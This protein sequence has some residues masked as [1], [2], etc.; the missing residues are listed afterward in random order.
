MTNYKTTNQMI[1]IAQETISISNEKAYLDLECNLHEFNQA[2]HP[3]PTLFPTNQ[4]TLIKGDVLEVSRTVSKPLVL[5]FSSC[6][7]PG[8][9]WLEGK[10][11]QEESIYFRTNLCNVGLQPGLFYLEK[12]SYPVGVKNAVVFRDADYE[13]SKP[14]LCDF[15]YLAAPV[16]SS[17]PEAMNKKLIV[18]RLKLLAT[19]VETNGY[20]SVVI[21]PWGCGAYGNN[22]RFVGETFKQIFSNLTAKVIVV[23]MDDE[24]GKIFEEVF[25]K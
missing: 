13:L 17:Y 10:T 3:T 5:I 4:F 7:R 19:F 9:G 24:N 8:G 21:G 12:G 23:I 14:W 11:T 22:P 2:L 25:Y 6:R 18:E 15:V 1:K 20:D 16:A